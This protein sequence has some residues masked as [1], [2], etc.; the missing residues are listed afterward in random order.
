MDASRFD[1]LTRHL[2]ARASR[3]TALGAALAGLG[4]ALG[5]RAA[6]QEATPATPGSEGEKPVFMFVQSFASGRGEANPA[7]GTP[8][9]HGPPSGGGASF[10]L[11]L[12]GHNG[13]TIYFSDRPD[14]IVG[15]I[16][17][18]VFLDTLGFS[19][20]N[21]PNAAL[22][23]EFESGQGV[24]VLKLIEP[25]YTPETG[26]V[27]YGAEV[28]EGYEGE[29]L[30]PVLADQ[31]A[32]RLPATIGPATLFIDDCPAYTTCYFHDEENDYVIELPLGPIPGGPYP[33]DWNGSSCEPL[34]PP[35][36]VLDQ[37]CRDAYQSE[38]W[39]IIYAGY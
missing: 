28:L 25:A 24:V 20:I 7:A 15:T 29:N 39:M 21:P 16:S 13:Q 31:V 30:T 38:D 22:V 8:T 6:A 3:R 26:T 32:A 27:V 11:T 35:K 12:G 19:P 37:L 18:E 9:V 10:L 33:T 2:G 4:L 17:T 14:R 36:P 34:F 1:Q 5:D 23:A